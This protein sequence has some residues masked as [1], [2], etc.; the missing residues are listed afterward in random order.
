MLRGESY[1]AFHD[2]DVTADGVDDVRLWCLMIL[3]VAIFDCQD[4]LLEW[5]LKS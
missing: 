2:D 5:I 4:Y 1:L 3:N